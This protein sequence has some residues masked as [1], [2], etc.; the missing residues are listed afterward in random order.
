M[1]LAWPLDSFTVG[2]SCQKSKTCLEVYNFQPPGRGEGLEIELITSAHDF[3]QSYLHNETSMNPPPPPND[4]ILGASALV[5]TWRCWKGGPR[6]GMV[7]LH[8]L[9]LA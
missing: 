9:S 6:E 2:T 1:T 4:E 7:A 3:D 8:P 5:N